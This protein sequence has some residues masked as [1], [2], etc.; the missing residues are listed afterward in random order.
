MAIFLAISLHFIASQTGM[1][2][3]PV[4]RL[5]FATWTFFGTLTVLA[6]VLL[7]ATTAMAVV[8]RTLFGRG[9]AHFIHVQDALE[10]CDFTPVYFERG[11][12][13][14]HAPPAEKWGPEAPTLHIC[15]MPRG[16]DAHGTPAPRPCVFLR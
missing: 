6:Y 10:E 4:Y 14:R 5:T 8:C 1:F 13:K 16:Q 7:V 3:S 9:L 15:V 2:V 12:A 11:D